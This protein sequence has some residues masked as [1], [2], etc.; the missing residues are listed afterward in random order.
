MFITLLALIWAV[1]VEPVKP[2]ARVSTPPLLAASV[3]VFVTALFEFTV[4]DPR[5]VADAATLALIVPPLITTRLPLPMIPSP[6]IVLFTLVRVW[7]LPCR[8]AVAPPFAGLELIV[9]VPPPFSVTAPVRFRVPLVPLPPFT[10]RV[11]LLVIVP[12][13]LVVSLPAKRAAV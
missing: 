12:T 11:P 10:R 3:P 4:R 7:L 2:F 9:S 6:W 5:W 1:P 8:R 13:M